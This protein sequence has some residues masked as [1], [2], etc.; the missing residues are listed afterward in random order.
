MLALSISIDDWVKNLLFSDFSGW[1][2]GFLP[3]QK[4]VYEFPFRVHFSL[5]RSDFAGITKKWWKLKGLSWELDISVH[6]QAFTLYWCALMNVDILSWFICHW[7]W[8][9]AIDADMM[10]LILIWTHWY[11]MMLLM[12][13]WMITM[14]WY[15]TIEVDMISLLSM[16]SVFS[17]I[18]GPAMYL[19]AK[20]TCQADVFLLPSADAN[21]LSPHGI[22]NK[23]CTTRLD[24]NKYRLNLMVYWYDITGC[25]YYVI[26][27][28]CDPMGSKEAKMQYDLAGCWYA[29]CNSNMSQDTNDYDA[30]VI[31]RRILT[32]WYIWILWTLSSA[33]RT[34]WT[35]GTNQLGQ[36]D[37]VK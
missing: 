8:Y 15:D 20:I 1:F 30:I 16:Q 12:V 6:A 4:K 14:I 31:S 13:K 26:G 11:D 2:S 22:W 10:S 35:L 9:N 36:S 5:N 33:E 18:W 7:H 17:S 29:T 37:S 34:I 27:C 24:T 21:K 23:L 19:L 25:R 32:E 28:R 3:I